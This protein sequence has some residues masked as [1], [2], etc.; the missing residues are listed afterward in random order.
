MEIVAHGESHER[1]IRLDLRAQHV[2][3]RLPG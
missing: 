1:F 3:S 2:R